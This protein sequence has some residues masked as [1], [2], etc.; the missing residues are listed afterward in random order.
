MSFEDKLEL[1]YSRINLSKAN[2]IDVGAHT[3]R[4]TIPIAK[5]IGE[6]G[7]VFAFEPVPSI[8]EILCKNLQVSGLNNAIIYPFA[9]S[10]QT[11]IA[12]FNF[13]PNLPEEGGLKRRHIY[14]T[15]PDA[16]VKIRVPVKRLD[17]LIPFN[18]TIDFIKIDVE[19]GELDVL[20]GGLELIGRSKPVVA[21]ECG[22]ASFLGYHKSPESIWDIFDSRGYLVYSI[23]GEYMDSA[24]KFSKASYEQK[25]WDYMALPLNKKEYCHYLR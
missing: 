5:I 6:A 9:L 1:F 3:G 20:E 12:E 11:H 8:R 4:H 21:F 7:M 16:F 25:Y 2:V 10:S 18:M 24:Q 14:N 22:A 13:I 19:G 17:D 15:L 23:T